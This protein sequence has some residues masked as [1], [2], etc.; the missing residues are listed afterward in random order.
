METHTEDNILYVT[1]DSEAELIGISFAAALGKMVQEG[2]LTL[3]QVEEV[4]N[5]AD[6]YTIKALDEHAKGKLQ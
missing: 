5:R 3:E 6:A 1:V 2:K 4:V